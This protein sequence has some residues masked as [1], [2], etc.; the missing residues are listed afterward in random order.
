MRTPAAGAGRGSVL[1]LPICAA[2]QARFAGGGFGFPVE[3]SS[4]CCAIFLFAGEQYISYTGA[5]A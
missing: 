4:Y 5:K 2:W 3:R 1:L